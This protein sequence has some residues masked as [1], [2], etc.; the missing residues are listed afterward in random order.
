M[1]KIYSLNKAG[2]IAF[3]STPACY[4][5]VASTNSTLTEDFQSSSFLEVYNLKGRCLSSV[6]TEVG[7]N[8]LAWS[9]AN[10]SKSLSAGI[11]AASQKDGVVSLYSGD[12]LFVPF[13]FR[14]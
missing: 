5:A 3:S 2:S 13:Y 11:L 12:K 6:K 10:P 7:Y 8:K 14:N 9:D 1:N 4:L